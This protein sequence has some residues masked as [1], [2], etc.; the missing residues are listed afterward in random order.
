MIRRL[1]VSSLLISILLAGCA[2]G[3][4]TPI[5]TLALNTPSAGN[6]TPTPSSSS[7]GGEVTAS[8]EIVPAQSADLAF[9]SLAVIR[10]IHVA[11]GDTVKAGQVLAEQDNVSMLQSAVDAAR[12]ALVTAQNNYNSLLANAPVSRAN[13]ELT[14]AQATKA[15]DDARKARDSKQFQRASQQTI[16]IAQ[17]NLI[18]ANKAL[19]DAE[20]I[21]NQ[22][23]N[24]SST[25]VVY[26]AALAQLAAAQQKQQQ[27]QYNLNYVSALPSPVDVTTAQANLD[28]AQA[29]L[30]AAKA[31]YERVKDGANPDDVAASQAQIAAAQSAI[32]AAQTA[33]DRAALKA[34]FDGTVVSVA[35]AAGETASPGQ[36]ILSLADLANLQAQ[37]TDLSERD[38]A[39]VQV[40]QP[41]S[42]PASPSPAW[43]RRSTARWCASR[44]RPAR[45]AATWSIRSPSSW[46]SRTPACAGACPPT[47]ISDN[48]HKNRVPEARV[49]PSLRRTPSR[50]PPKF[51]SEF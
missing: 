43:A 15:F 12:A 23:K 11:E 34:P 42:R 48:S 32:A 1:I 13:A 3:A 6:R 44:K 37:T 22:N 4:A 47:S 45:S 51:Q 10:A 17:A 5:P 26:A 39:R 9:A 35:A 36:V 28:V 49:N 50:P 31:A 41:A 40:G 16:D 7:S 27:A 46:T 21:Y 14:L 25:D 2:S 8:A 24:R 33:L 18:V 30:D 19:E 38:V 29:N 20:T